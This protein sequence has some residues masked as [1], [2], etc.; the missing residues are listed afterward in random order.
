MP[1]L[2]AVWFCCRDERFSSEEHYEWLKDYSHFRHLIQ[3]HVKPISKVFFFFI[4][5]EFL[6]DFAGSISFFGAKL[7]ASVVSLNMGIGASLQ[8]H[9][10]LKENLQYGKLVIVM[11][12]NLQEYKFEAFLEDS[13]VFL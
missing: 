3:Q 8:N 10:F 12:R 11:H 4:F 7:L 2:D 13:V 1:R 6:L 5:V 9:E